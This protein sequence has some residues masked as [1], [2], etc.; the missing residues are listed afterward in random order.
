MHELCADTAGRRLGDGWGAHSGRAARMSFLFGRFSRA[1]RLR[2][3][4]RFVSPNKLAGALHV[5]RTL[6]ALPQGD[7]YCIRY[8]IFKSLQGT[9]RHT[10]DSARTLCGA[11]AARIGLCRMRRLRKTLSVWRASYREYEKRGRAVW[12]MTRLFIL[13]YAGRYA[14]YVSMKGEI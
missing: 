13:L 2:R 14:A 3:R 5:L 9:G 7:R 12:K 6:R 1:A 4:A 8:K 10:G 11:A